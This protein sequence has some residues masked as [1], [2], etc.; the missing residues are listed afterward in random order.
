MPESI[1]PIILETLFPAP[2]INCLAEFDHKR[3]L[4]TNIPKE[5]THFKENKLKKRNK[6]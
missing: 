6:D 5:I 4:K 3:F 2:P 1:E